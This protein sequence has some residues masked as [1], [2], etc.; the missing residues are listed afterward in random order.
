MLLGK[1]GG[2]ESSK[3]EN[4]MMQ[5]QQWDIHK[6]DANAKKRKGGKEKTCLQNFYKEFLNTLIPKLLK[7]I[8]IKTH[9]QTNSQIFVIF[10]RK[11]Q[12]HNQQWKGSESYWKVTLVLDKQFR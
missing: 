10:S 9:F 5:E 3:M 4:E 2:N 11:V 1:E 6:S 12:K 7:S 8:N